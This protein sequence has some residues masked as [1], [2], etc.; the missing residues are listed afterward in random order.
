MVNLS[1]GTSRSARLAGTR[2]GDRDV[3]VAGQRQGR[4]SFGTFEVDRESGELLKRGSPLRVQ[5]KP[6]QLLLLLLEHPGEI[7]LREDLQRRLWPNG[8]YVDFDKGLNTAVKK[9]RYALG[10]SPDKPVFI[11]TIP[12]RGYRF[13]ASVQSQARNQRRK[14]E[15]TDKD[16]SVS[17][18]SR[19][20]RKRLRRRRSACCCVSR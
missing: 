15:I 11:E 20:W 5:E 6:L 18:S 4:L 7:V 9:L 13:I 12:R 19:R 2:L 17:H 14:E 8:T 1:P 10:D 3:A 16:V